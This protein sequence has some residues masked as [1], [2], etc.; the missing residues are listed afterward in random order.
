M[1][2]RSFVAATLFVV[3]V[4]GHGAMQFPVSR[5]VHNSHYCPQCANGASVCGSGEGTQWPADDAA[6]SQ[7]TGTYTTPLTELVAGGMVEVEAFFTAAHMGHFA[8]ELCANPGATLSND[9]FQ[10]LERD[11]SDTRHSPYAASAPWA[12][13]MPVN[14]CATSFSTSSPMKVR[15]QVPN[16]LS[17]HAVLRWHWQ[18]G[19][20]CDSLPETQ[21]SNAPSSVTSWSASINGKSCTAAL[22]GA[23]RLC[24]TDCPNPACTNEQFRNC[25]DI[26]IVSGNPSTVVSSGNHNTSEAGNSSGS[27]GNNNGGSNNGGSNNGG[28]NNGGSN[29]GGSNN[30]GSN[31]GNSG[32]NSGSGSSEVESCKN[33]VGSSNP[34]WNEDCLAKCEFYAANPVYCHGS[35]LVDCVKV[36]TGYC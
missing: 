12:A 34:A 14:S 36:N 27:G 25:A 33:S 22:T 21:T 4:A 26:K 1:L 10:K 17:E 35:P 13:I 30:G 20:S 3:D 9:C 6:A 15:F 28:S 18:S 5:N 32:G 29:N 16:S 24:G 23:G 7:L 2:V 11:S 19:N 31:N 8:L